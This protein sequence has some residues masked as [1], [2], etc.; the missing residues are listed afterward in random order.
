M[1]YSYLILISLLASAALAAESR[2]F[3]YTVDPVT[4]D[5]WVG[6]VPDMKQ[7]VTMA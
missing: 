4:G 1:K 2:K 3:T 6:S 7:V 5:D